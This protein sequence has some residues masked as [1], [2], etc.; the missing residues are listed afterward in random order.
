MSWWRRLFR[1]G[2]Q[3]PAK[4]RALS[5]RE[6]YQ[7]K[8]RL[9]GEILAA[10]NHALEILAQLQVLLHSREYF[11]PAYLSLTFTLLLDQG[12]RVVRLLGQFLRQG[13]EELAAAWERLEGQLAGAF[14]ALVRAAAQAGHLPFEQSLP[15]GPE[16]VASGRALASREAG[17]Q[18]LLIKAVWGWWPAVQNGL[19]PARRYLVVQGQV[20][21]LP[22]PETTTQEQWLIYQPEHGFVMAPLS[23]AYQ[24]QAC[25]R[26]EEI[27]LLAEYF[28]QLKARDPE[29]GELEWALGPERELLV[30]R[31]RAP[32]P[33]VPGLPPTVP[34]SELLWRGKGVTIYPG[35]AS[36]PAWP[37]GSGFPPVAADIPA[38]AI[39]F[40]SKPTLSLAPLLSQA[41]ALVVESGEAYNHLA[42]VA[43]EVGLPAIFALGEDTSRIPRESLVTVAA[44]QLTIL[45]GPLAGTGNLSPPLPSPAFPAFE[46]LRS[47]RSLLFP[48]RE[49]IARGEARPE[50][51]RSFHDFLV[52]ATLMH[53]EDMAGLSLHGEVERQEAVHLVTERLI[54]IQVVNG[55]GGL[56]G[57]G[58]RVSFN[59]VTSL[60][61]RALLSGMLSIPWPKGRPLDVKGFL[62]VIGVTSTT[63]QAEKQLEKIS[64][65]LITDRYVNFS[66][67]LGYHVSTI[68][69]YAGAN[70]DHN[71]IRFRY[72]GGAASLDRR[73]RRLQ[74]IGE[75]LAHLGFQ[76][77]IT[78][79]SLEALSSHD[80]EP[81]VIKKLEILGRLEVYTKQMDMLL[82]DES[83]VSGY[84]REFLE[85]YAGADR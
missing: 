53:R 36:G 43:R 26:P 57:K 49:E 68:E 37:L 77:G 21:E 20:R 28:S 78:G 35:W 44:H 42:L 24:G 15:S 2:Q 12:R 81:M 6:Q 56:A 41:A 11:T 50:L 46:L 63:P 75:I 60:P 62:S 67:C 25:L 31:A 29:V 14:P 59:E 85:K 38:G 69:A 39:L 5:L 45:K 48:L 19:I 52:V 10:T 9:S 64:L 32:E 27:F 30:L 71:F 76:V 66:L 72:Q 55:G 8:L 70:Q 23:P 54:P 61:F 17:D 74:L 73:L 1:R 22:G 3:P 83:V 47:L 51:I 34:A 4:R 7:R 82:A 13:G 80:P 16:L 58:P 18:S 79:D 40:A 84:V 33:E 65:A